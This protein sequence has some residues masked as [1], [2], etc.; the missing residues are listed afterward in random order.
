MNVAFCPNQNIRPRLYEPSPSPLAYLHTR[1]IPSSQQPSC[2]SAINSRIL[3][4][5]YPQY[6]DSN[7]V[8]QQQHQQNHQCL[9]SNNISY[10]F[11]SPNEVASSHQIHNQNAINNNI[12]RF[13][14]SSIQ[15]HPIPHPSSS[16]SPTSSPG[17]II[18][19]LNMNDNYISLNSAQSYSQQ[20]KVTPT[21]QT[22]NNQ[23][24]QNYQIQLQQQH[25]YPNYNS[26]VAALATASV[27]SK[28][29]W[30]ADEDETLTKMYEQIGPQ[31]ARIS[32]VLPGRTIS[33]IRSRRNAI[34]SRK[35][36]RQKAAM[37]QL[38]ITP[39][40]K[41][42]IEQN[43]SSSAYP[44]YLYSYQAPQPTN[45]IY[46]KHIESP[47]LIKESRNEQFYCSIESLLN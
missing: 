12:S 32:E 43:Q 38:K 16:P 26:I 1:T 37:K 41:S 34:E 28:A 4:H 19:G 42:R 47:N 31:W 44:S 27:E 29:P 10:N 6:D 22:Q 5:Q 14:Q 8:Y 23:N 13:Q 20:C 35:R 46:P 40:L 17:P 45:I 33:Q 9:S 21:P 24:S 39:E 30:S 11:H 18:S 2:G 7:I 36:Q 3:S 15:V 25:M